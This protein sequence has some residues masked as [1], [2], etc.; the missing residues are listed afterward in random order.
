MPGLCE[1]RIFAED[2]FASQSSPATDL[3]ARIPFTFAEISAESAIIQGLS[4][5]Y[6]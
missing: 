4:L 3:V 5:N 6:R 1:S 2:R